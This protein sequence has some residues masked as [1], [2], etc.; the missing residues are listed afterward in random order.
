MAAGSLEKYCSEEEIQELKKKAI[1]PHIQEATES[2]SVFLTDDPNLNYVCGSKGDD[3]D[4]KRLKENIEYI[5]ADDS[6][7]DYSFVSQEEAEHDLKEEVVDYTE[8][9]E[10]GTSDK[11]KTLSFL[12]VSS[13]EEGVEWYRTNFPKVP[14][15]LLEPM[16]RWNFG[17]LSRITKK[18]IKNDKKRVSR[19]KKPKVIQGLQIKKGPVVVKF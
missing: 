7:I 16:A 5:P 12:N 17:D 8:L 19:G 18:D 2:C 6:R 4:F 1:E 10:K 11:R 9:K 14:E 13:V 3:E 15:E